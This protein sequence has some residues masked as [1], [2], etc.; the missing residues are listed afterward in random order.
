MI[1][2]AGLTPA[3]QQILVFDT[4]RYGEVNRACEA[5]WCASGKVFNAGIAAH[6]LGGPSLTLSPVGGSLR[7]AIE[8]EMAGLKVPCRWVAAQAPTRVCTT[9]L[10][11]ATGAMTE[12]VEEGRRFPPRSWRNSARRTPRRPARR[13]GGDYRLAPRGY[14]SDVLSRSGRTNAVPGRAG[15]PR[16]GIVGGARSPPLRGQ[17]EPRGV[18]RDIGKAAGARR[19]PSRRH[20]GT[21][22]AG[23]AMGG[24]DP[25]ERSGLGDRR[26]ARVAR[27]T[28]GSRARGEP[29]RLWRRAG[30]RDGLGHAAGRG[31]ARRGAAGG[32]RGGGQSPAALSLPL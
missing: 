20:G 12:L 27:C 32:G 25:G 7:G 15:F 11:R 2:S 23:G 22:P 14:S 9:I 16:A 18:E 28:A 19:G 24:S 1:L 17:A 3:W 4:F 26:R 31:S 29:H 6:R 8:E 10:E 21:Q 5:H 30:G 13:R